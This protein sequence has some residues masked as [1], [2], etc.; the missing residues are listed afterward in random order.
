VTEVPQ[1][2][3]EP[4][5]RAPEEAQ[6]LTSQT[7]G[8]DAAGSTE[9]RSAVERISEVLRSAEVAA[10]AIRAEAVSEADE[11]RRTA[12]EEGERHLSE[13]K[14][15][16]ARVREAEQRV[17]KMLA[18]AEAQARAT[19]QAEEEA[20]RRVEALR[21]REEKL[22]AYIGPLETTLTRALEGFRGITAQLEELLDD[23]QAR[24]GETLVEALSE[25][26]R[27]TGEREETAPPQE[28]PSG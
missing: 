6:G 20:S 28:R 12:T 10:E 4:Q 7:E 11:I 15:E 17:D 16:A 3:S 18:D 23:E 5:P 2:R 1:D 19:R 25:P 13:V 14:E 21:E 26:V 27:R 9:H 22:K 24:E 8:S